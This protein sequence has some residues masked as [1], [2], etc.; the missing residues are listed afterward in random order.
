MGAWPNSR[1]V[2]FECL[3][4]VRSTRQRQLSQP[5]EPLQVLHECDEQRLFR[6]ES[7]GSRPI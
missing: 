2:D 7:Q 1:K 6:H 4:V 3:V 5:H